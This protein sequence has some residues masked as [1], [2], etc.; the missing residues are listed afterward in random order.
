MFVDNRSRTEKKKA[1]SKDQNRELIE[2][3]DKN[4]LKKS[5]VE[6]LVQELEEEKAKNARLEKE[7]QRS[8]KI[9]EEHQ[10]GTS[11]TEDD[12]VQHNPNIEF[13]AENRL[14]STRNMVS[15]HS[16][17]ESRFLSSMNQLSVASI[18][19]GECKASEDGE[20]HRQT[21]ELW[22]DLMIDSLKLAG[23]EDES[24]KFT[25]LR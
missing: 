18:N 25:V 19:V 6:H 7:L 20:I 9:N 22:K 23:I 11:L 2:K 1:S 24:T 8:L 13:N 21:F 12:S 17:E 15:T 10:T 5:K 14:C 3:P 4:R 16:L